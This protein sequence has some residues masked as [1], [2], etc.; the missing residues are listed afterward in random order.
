MAAADKTDEGTQVCSQH[1][2][3]AQRVF[4]KLGLLH[5]LRCWIGLLRSAYNPPGHLL[6]QDGRTRRHIQPYFESRFPYGD[7][8]RTTS[9]FRLRQPIGQRWHRH[10]PREDRQVDLHDV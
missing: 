8:H 4:R 7:D 1:Q 10:R 3:S 5:T 2:Y 9:G 6:L